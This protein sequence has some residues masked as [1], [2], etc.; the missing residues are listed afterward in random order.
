MLPAHT[1]ELPPQQTFHLTTQA[2]G[3]QGIDSNMEFWLWLEAIVTVEGP[4]HLVHR[5]VCPA[6]IYH[7][8]LQCSVPVY[9][10]RLVK[11]LLG[12]QQV[13]NKPDTW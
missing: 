4:T 6:W 9:G 7:V 11:I 3:L 13:H 10:I 12:A 1:V 5:S 2:T 8:I